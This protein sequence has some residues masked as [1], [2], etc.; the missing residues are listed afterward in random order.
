[1]SK[2]GQTEWTNTLAGWH[3]SEWF[4]CC[5]KNQPIGKTWIERRNP[6]GS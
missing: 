5:V 2:V 1:M 4:R 3:I 6:T